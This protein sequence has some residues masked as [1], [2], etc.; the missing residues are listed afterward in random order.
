L[1]CSACTALCCCCC[2]TAWGEAL[3]KTQQG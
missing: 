3:M 1:C 2:C